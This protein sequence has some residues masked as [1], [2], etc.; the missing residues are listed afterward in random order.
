MGALHHGPRLRPGYQGTLRQRGRRADVRLVYFE[1]HGLSSRHAGRRRVYHWKPALQKSDHTPRSPISKRKIVHRYRGEQ[2]GGKYLHPIG[3]V[4]WQALGARLA[5]LRRNCGGWKTGTGD[6]R[7]AE[8]EL[9][10]G[11][12]RIAAGAPKILDRELNIGLFI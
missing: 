8:Q 6:G 4:E 12:G 9:G 11:A 10:F 2:F 1:R 5:A 7:G 3:E